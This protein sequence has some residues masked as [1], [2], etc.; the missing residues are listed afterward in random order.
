MLSLL[1]G[2]DIN[3]VEKTGMTMRF[4]ITLMTRVPLFPPKLGR[5]PNLT[6]ASTTTTTTTANHAVLSAELVAA[7]LTLAGL[8]P[9]W[10]Q[11]Y[12]KQVLQYVRLI[13]FVI[14]FFFV[15]CICL[16]SNC[17]LSIL[18]G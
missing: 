18:T 12:F 3:D 9:E 10:T 2:I 5:V 6:S 16:L 17:Y 1:P 13:V 8:F 7:R 14:F 4:Y 15:W 11:A